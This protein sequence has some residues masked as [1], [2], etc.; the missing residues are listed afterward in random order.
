MTLTSRQLLLCEIQ[1]RLFEHLARR[2][3]DAKAF[4]R[5]FMNSKAAE[6]LDADYDRMQWAGEAYIFED[7]MEE[8]GLKRDPNCPQYD[9]EALYY[10]GFITR[11]WNFLTGESSR[12]IYAQCDENELLERDK[13]KL[14][15]HTDGLYKSRRL[16]Y[17]AKN[18]VED[19]AHCKKCN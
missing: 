2:Q 18:E 11:Y 19:C 1:G 3:V 12:E 17:V 7:V 9:A 16:I 14:N 13:A 8:S 5:A 6:G 10:G 15:T 4:I